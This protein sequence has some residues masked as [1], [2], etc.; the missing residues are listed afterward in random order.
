MRFVWL[1]AILPRGARSIGRRALSDRSS[2]TGDEEVQEFL[3]RN[4]RNARHPTVSVTAARRE[5]LALYRN[6]LRAA[7]LFEWPDEHGYIWRRRI[8]ESARSEFELNRHVQSGEQAAQLVVQGQQAL[9]QVVQKLA[10]KAG[11]SRPPEDQPP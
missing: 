7:R 10:Q 9:E 4:V 5:A 11:Y 2:S 8:E 3:Q 6:V 1:R